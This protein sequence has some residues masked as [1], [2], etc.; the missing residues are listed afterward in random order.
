MTTVLIVNAGSST[1]KLRVLGAADEVTGS[2]DLS[3]WDGT[4][5]DPGLRDFLDGLA[6]V[7][8]VGHRV[9][10]G[11]H[12]FTAATPIDDDVVAGIE[13][14]TD[15]A[16]LHQPRALAGIAAVRAAMPGV[17]SVACFDT[18]FHAGLPAAAASY[19]LPVAWTQR[20]GLRRFGFHGLSHGYA[21]G[22]AAQL[23]GNGRG[24]GAGA[25]PGRGGGAGASP[26]RGG[27]A[28]DRKSVV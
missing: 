2:A 6:G 10:H 18:A 28:G 1:L 22:R 13:A 21:A 9:V 27:G 5:D 11:G 4:P 25:S 20:F 14:L 3:P 19:A 8:A 17:P 12:R 24:G 26:G 16:P 15:L 7:G 23:T